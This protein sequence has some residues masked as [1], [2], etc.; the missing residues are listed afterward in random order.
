MGGGVRSWRALRRAQRVPVFAGRGSDVRH[1]GRS[2]FESVPGLL[3]GRCPQS[4]LRGPLRLG[5]AA[6][7][8]EGT[9]G[10]G[11]SGKRAREPQGLLFFS[12]STW[13]RRAPAIPPA[14]RRDLGEMAPSTAVGRCTCLTGAG[15]TR[16]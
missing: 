7:G 4:V 13:Q 6:A 1:P 8:A 16:S 9:R 11:V 14:S 2:A 10:V 15:R 12:P 5:A 3:P